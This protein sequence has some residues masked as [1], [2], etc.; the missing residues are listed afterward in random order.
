MSTMKVIGDKRVIIKSKVGKDSNGIKIPL[1]NK[2][3][4][5]IILVMT[6]TSDVFSVGLEAI[7]TPNKELINPI[8]IIAPHIRM[9][10]NIDVKTI[11]KRKR[12]IMVIID[13]I[14]NE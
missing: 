13:V 1:I 6:I 12:K 7:S 9:R 14:I 10:E 2:R 5:L 11:F 8:K 4:N 3:G